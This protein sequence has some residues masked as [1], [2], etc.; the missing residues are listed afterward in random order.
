VVNILITFT[1]I[2]FSRVF[3]R[4]QH[5]EDAFTIFAKMLTF[6][7]S[8]MKDGA[9]ILIYC[10]L[11]IFFLL[12]VEIKKEFFNDRFSFSNNKNFWVRNLY[13][14]F[15]MLMIF[16]FGVYDGGQFIYFQF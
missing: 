9:A 5:V 8:I 14:S 3:F 4:A 13:F 7:G 12:A 10:F 1:L 6:K 2:C 15:L 11:A 16:L